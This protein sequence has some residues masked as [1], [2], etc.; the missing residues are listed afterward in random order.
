MSEFSEE[1]EL[2]KEIK[3]SPFFDK[4][5]LKR[6][7]TREDRERLLRNI[8]WMP[9]VSGEEFLANLAN[10]WLEMEDIYME[11]EDYHTTYKG[12]DNFFQIL[13]Y[14][15]ANFKNNA[16]RTCRRQLHS[17]AIAIK[18]QLLLGWIC[19]TTDFYFWGKGAEIEKL[20]EK[21]KDVIEELYKKDPENKE[22]SYFYYAGHTPGKRE[23]QNKLKQIGAQMF[24][25]ELEADCYFRFSG[26]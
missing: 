22:I 24:P 18:I 12:A 14:V 15:E 10:I 23:R 19:S 8:K 16:Y 5:Y 9:E 4:E 17:D 13:Q 20:Q 26:R 25:T 3:V 11:R 6:A 2:E 1:K 7:E 21:N